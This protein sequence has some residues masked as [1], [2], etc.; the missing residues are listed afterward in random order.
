MSMG[1]ASGRRTIAAWLAALACLLAAS[2]A[3]AADFVDSVGRKVALPAK[4]ERVVPAGPPA[5]ALLLAIA[6]EKLVGLVEPFGPRK[7][8]FLPPAGP[9][10]RRSLASP[11]RSSRPTSMCSGR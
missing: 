11:A 7:K 5:D 4:I 2:A 8:V 10:C 6:P 1:V 3:P 9:H